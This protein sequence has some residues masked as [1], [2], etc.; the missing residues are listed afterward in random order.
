MRVVPVGCRK[1]CLRRPDDRRP[2]R[3]MQ[4]SQR[5]NQST[6]FRSPAMLRLK[7]HHADH[8]SD[9]LGAG[10]GQRADAEGTSPELN[11]TG[12]SVWKPRVH[13][14]RKRQ[15][16]PH[17]VSGVTGVPVSEGELI[18]R[19]AANGRKNRTRSAPVD[20]AR[21]VGSVSSEG[22]APFQMSGRQFGLKCVQGAGG[23]GIP[24]ASRQKSQPASRT[25]SVK[26]VQ[27]SFP[28]ATCE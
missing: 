5:R 26:H 6:T 1:A 9:R 10:V 2:G 12:A 28:M 8:G 23:R 21:P 7:P 3:S 19:G 20:Q 22:T 11:K 27:G 13:H 14:H 25:D 17:P 24:W 15:R 4:L 16:S 18:V